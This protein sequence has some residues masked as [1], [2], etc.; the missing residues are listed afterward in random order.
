MI[1]GVSQHAFERFCKRQS[2]T[3][4]VLFGSTAAGKMT[5]HSDL[6]LAFWIDGAR[7]DE[8]ELMLA[9]DLMKLF[10][11]NDVDG[12]VLNHADPLMQWQVA[13]TGALLYEKA[14]GCFRWFQSYAM[15]RYDDSKRLLALQ[16]RFLDRVVRRVPAAWQTN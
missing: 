13:S 16:D 12:I 5:A 6:D 4:A 11:R 7:R 14:R 2:I 9:N 1:D 10:H 3:L 8:Q 15:K